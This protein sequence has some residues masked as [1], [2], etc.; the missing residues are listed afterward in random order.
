MV[1]C[2]SALPQENYIDYDLADLEQK[3]VRLTEEQVLWKLLVELILDSLQRAVIPVEMLDRLSFADVMKIRQPFWSQAS[4]TST[5]NWSNP[6]SGHTTLI[7][8]CSAMLISWRK[9]GSSS[10]ELLVR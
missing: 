9:S 1:N 6:L 7:P 2:E 8:L 4:S 5:I 3:R 10:H